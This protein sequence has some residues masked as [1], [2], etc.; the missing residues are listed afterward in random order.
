[1]TLFGRKKEE[2][3]DVTKSAPVVETG[4]KLQP[5]SAKLPLGTDAAAYAVILK[6]HITEKASLM[7]DQR[8]YIFRVSPFSNKIQ[9][10]RSIEKLYKV[11]VKAVTILSMP[12]K[13]RHVGRY[14][15]VKP[16]FKKA[17]ITLVE[18]DK[19]EVAG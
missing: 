5:S 15:G 12:A 8:K 13:Y 10:K 16:G 7:A 3:K 17:I 18:G 14:E 19:I 2:K 1:M 9:V 6:P 11:K 4:Q